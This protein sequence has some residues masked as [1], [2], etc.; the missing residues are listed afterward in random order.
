M[1]GIPWQSSGWDVALSL[2][3]PWGSI[4]GQG[5]K[6]PASLVIHHP[7]PHQKDMVYIYERNVNLKKKKG[8]LRHATIEDLEDITIREI[9]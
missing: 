3:W 4:P 5:T 8:V 2:P 9:N 7:R 6:I 1:V